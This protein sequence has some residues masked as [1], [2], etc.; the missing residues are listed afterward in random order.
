M[1]IAIFGSGG[2]G[3]YFGGRLAQS[4]EDVV[5]IAR[6]AH[7]HA[8]R[9]RGLRVSSISGDFTVRPVHATDDPATVGPVDAVLL[10]VKAWQ[11]PEAARAMH[12]LIGPETFVVPL[13]NGVE[14][15]EEL[16]AV[17]GAGHVLGGL[18]R[19]L[20]YVTGP[21]E[22]R[23]AAVEPYLAFGELD[24]TRS[25]RAEALRR[26]FART[27]GVTVEIPADI[28]AAMWSKFLFIT[29]VSGLGALTRVPIGILRT[30]RET[31]QLLVEALSEIV[32]LAA[33]VGVVLPGDAVEQTLAFT[34]GIPADGTTS[35][36]RDIMEGR[37]SE[38]DAQVGAVVRLGT[39]ARVAVPVHRFMYAA[40]LPLERRIRGE[41]GIAP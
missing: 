1:R 23:H 13:E 40:L 22:I 12:P 10:A 21:G 15:P 9:E 24:G 18:C 32:P 17:L 36:Q 35:M 7:L 2:V 8:L 20:A 37:P 19:I 39:R 26:A 38:L 41:H 3:G 27:T 30:T 5:F 28:R 6:G 16:A 33:A 31:R 29:P 11:I 25:E 4:G 14:A 34:D